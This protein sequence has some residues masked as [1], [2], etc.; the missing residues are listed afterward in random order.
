MITLERTTY[1]GPATVLE[2]APGRIKLEFPD[3]HAWATSAV[4]FPYQ[5]TPDDVVLAAGRSGEW[6][7]IGVLKAKGPTTLLVSGDLTIAAPRGRMILEAAKGV[8]VKSR[9]VRITARRL[10]VMARQLWE[11]FTE[12]TRWIQES[13]QLRAGSMRTRVEDSYDLHAERIRETADEDI[14]IHGRTINLG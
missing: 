9:E 13:F 14:K 7:V 3:E 12:A 2:V 10:E 6:Y 1:L 8:E 4:A 5:A 11:R